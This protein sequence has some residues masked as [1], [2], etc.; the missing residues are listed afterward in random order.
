MACRESEFINAV[1]ASDLSGSK[2]QAENSLAALEE[3]INN[4]EPFFVFG[5][6]KYSFEVWST[7]NLSDPANYKKNGSLL[8]HEMLAQFD[9]MAKLSSLINNGLN[10]AIVQY[11]AKWVA[12]A[13]VKRKQEQ[14]VITPDDLLSNL[15]QALLS[16]QGQALSEKIAA[17]FP[18]AMIDEFQDTDPVQYG[19]SR[20]YGIKNTTLA[21]IGDPKQA[22]YGFRSGAGYLLIL[23]QNKPFQMTSNTP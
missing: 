3:Y 13:L 14:G 16:E 17:L 12:N 6:S 1:K 9:E 21:M 8:S 11:A 18:V 4:D 22:I 5:T 2:P 20:I 15:H 19:I 7:E 23:A 10:I